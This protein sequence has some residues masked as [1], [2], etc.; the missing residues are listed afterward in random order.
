MDVQTREAT[1]VA[2]AR[3]GGAVSRVRRITILAEA[4][5]DELVSEPDQRRREVLRGHFFAALS[6]S[7]VDAA[8]MDELDGGLVAPERITS[9]VRMMTA[10]EAHA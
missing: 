1:A 10:P 9:G 4:L 6:D 7:L 8:R 2:V 5:A 3:S